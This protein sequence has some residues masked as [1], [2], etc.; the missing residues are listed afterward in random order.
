[1]PPDHLGQ[2]PWKRT[3]LSAD[4]GVELADSDVVREL[5][6][7][8]LGVALPFRSV[9]LTSLLTPIA[10]EAPTG[11][12]IP[13]AEVPVSLSPALAITLSAALSPIPR[14]F[15]API[16]AVTTGAVA[17]ARRTAETVIATGTLPL[18]G[19]PVSGAAPA[20]TSA[21]ASALSTPTSKARPGAIAL[22]TTSATG[23]ARTVPPLVASSGA[24]SAPR[25]A[26]VSHAHVRK[27][28]KA[29]PLTRSSAW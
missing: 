20:C 27:Q 1:M 6:G 14:P 29:L 9:P 15:A 19:P 23:T 7:D 2:R 13:R 11:A 21:V 10:V 5:R 18:S 4:L 25:S 3:E 17:S 12:A 8:V 28:S 26:F 16:A 22:A 24:A